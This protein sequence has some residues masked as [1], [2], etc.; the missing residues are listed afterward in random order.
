[1]KDCRGDCFGAFV[2]ANGQ[3]ACPFAVKPVENVTPTLLAPRLRAFVNCSF[4]FLGESS[5]RVSDTM[6]LMAVFNW[7][8]IGAVCCWFILVLCVAYFPR[9]WLSV[10]KRKPK[11][12]VVEH[13]NSSPVI[14]GPSSSAAVN[15]AEPLHSVRSFRFDEAFDPEIVE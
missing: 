11:S 12:H 14:L 10:C 4:D 9:R 7:F 15:V 8:I 6:K 5:K 2:I 3:C 1:M 13:V